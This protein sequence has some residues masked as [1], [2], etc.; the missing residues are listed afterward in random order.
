M[1]KIEQT[2]AGGIGHEKE[3]LAPLER[4]SP[5]TNPKMSNPDALSRLSFTVGPHRG[6]GDPAFP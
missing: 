5:L 6:P 4:R 2:Q 3:R 1:E